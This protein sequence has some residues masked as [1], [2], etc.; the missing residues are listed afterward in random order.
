MAEYI[1]AII[2]GAITLLGGRAFFEWLL[3]PI[4]VVQIVKSLEL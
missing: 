4:A 2:K 3:S 1:V